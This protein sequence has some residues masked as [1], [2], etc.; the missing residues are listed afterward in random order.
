[1]FICIQKAVKHC[2]AQNRKFTI[3]V[4]FSGVQQLSFP[5]IHTD[6]SKVAS[7]LKSFSLHVK[8]CVGN[9][10]KAEENNIFKSDCTNFKTK[11]FLFILQKY[12]LPKSTC[13]QY[14]VILF[15]P[16]PVPCIIMLSDNLHV[17]QTKL[18]SLNTMQ[19]NFNP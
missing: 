16:I 7:T 10:L 12:V 2:T 14:S 1:M 19:I 17:K 18:T 3:F 5:N 8:Q 6:T 4:F 11:F 15:S 9:K 13:P